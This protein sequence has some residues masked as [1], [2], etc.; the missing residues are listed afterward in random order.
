MKRVIRLGD[1][2]THGGT[3]IQVAATQTD[4]MGKPLARVGDQCV[5][6][7]P[8]HGPCAI[9]EVLQGFLW[10]LA[11]RIAPLIEQAPPCHSRESGNP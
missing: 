1:P 8:G 10:V 11:D 4:V 3:V 5:C 9:I 2:T 6:P 7:V